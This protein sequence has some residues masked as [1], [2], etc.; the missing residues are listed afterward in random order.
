MT[1]NFLILLPPP[2]ECW[3]YCCTP[4]IQLGSTSVHFLWRKQN[5][6]GERSKGHVGKSTEEEVHIGRTSMSHLPYG[7]HISPRG[8]ELVDG[9]LVCPSCWC[10]VCW[11]WLKLGPLRDFVMSLAS[12]DISVPADCLNWVHNPYWVLR[13]VSVALEISSL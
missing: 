10:N 8:S 3:D 7:R 11:P 4:H 9:H 6:D 1:F 12:V 5:Q 2:P 13:Y